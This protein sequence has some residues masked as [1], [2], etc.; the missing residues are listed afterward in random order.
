MNARAT[1]PP[2][3]FSVPAIQQRAVNAPRDGIGGSGGGKAPVLQKS[4]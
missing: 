2:V 1:P 3:S 4:R